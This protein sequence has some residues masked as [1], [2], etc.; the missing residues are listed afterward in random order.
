VRRKL[1]S[2]DKGATFPLEFTSNLQARKEF[3]RRLQFQV[4][5]RIYK[6]VFFL[7]SETQC[8]EAIGLMTSR[9]DVQFFYASPIIWMRN[10]HPQHLKPP[11][12][13]PA[14]RRRNDLLP[15]GCL[16]RP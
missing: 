8:R 4:G 2:Y 1:S 12:H 14:K 15:P 3:S 9:R 5:H 6:E 10:S 16:F 11:C 13:H 7:L